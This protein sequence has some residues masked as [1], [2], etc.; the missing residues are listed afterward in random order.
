MK[1]ALDAF[2]PVLVNGHHDLL[3][4]RGRRR[5]VETPP[6]TEPC[7][8][9]ASTGRHE[10]PRG[11]HPGWRRELGQCPA[12]KDGRGSTLER[13]A[14]EPVIHLMSRGAPTAPFQ[15][16][17]WPLVLQWMPRVN[18]MRLL[19][20]AI[21]LYTTCYCFVNENRVCFLVMFEDSNIRFRA[22]PIYTL[23]WSLSLLFIVFCW[24]GSI[25]MEER[26][27]EIKT[28]SLI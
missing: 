1:R 11:V 12:L 26:G 15:S 21:G 16:A 5:D 17:R 28:S 7:H 14:I 27:R 9:R 13:T 24:C 10:T 25:F 23:P 3:D 20:M 22:V 6:R 8:Q 18:P 19:I 2:V 4:Q